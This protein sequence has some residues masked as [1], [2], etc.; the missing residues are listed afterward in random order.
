MTH[1]PGRVYSDRRR[2]LDRGECAPL[3]LAD[4]TEGEDVRS[5]DRSPQEVAADVGDGRTRNVN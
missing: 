5:L 2:V 3:L 4:F 1:R